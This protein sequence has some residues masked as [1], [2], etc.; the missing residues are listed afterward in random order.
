MCKSDGTSRKTLITNL[1][2]PRA[3]AVDVHLGHMYWSE[4][5]STPRIA[6]ALTDGSNVI[7]LVDKDIGWPN[8]MFLF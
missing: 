8:G 1:S 5:G 2:K 3:L 4:W 6:R 7:T